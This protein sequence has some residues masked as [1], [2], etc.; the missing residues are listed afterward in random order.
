MCAV[1]DVTVSA[2]AKAFCRC[3][4][5]EGVPL[6]PQKPGQLQGDPP[7]APISSGECEHVCGLGGLVPFMI[8][9][10]AFA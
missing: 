9:K 7:G 10:T 6:A 5:G 8:P 2:A 4:R 1:F 3:V